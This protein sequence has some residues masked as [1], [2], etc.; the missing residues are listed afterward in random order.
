MPVGDDVQLHHRR[1][2]E[3]V[4]IVLELGFVLPV[5]PRR[6]EPLLLRQAFGLQAGV[7]QQAGG[8]PHQHLGVLLAVSSV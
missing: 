6:I 8:P 7:H 1:R 3:A 4:E 5:I 2:E